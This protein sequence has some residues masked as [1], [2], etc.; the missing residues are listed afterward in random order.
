ME[1]AL[2]PNSSIEELD[3]LSCVEQEKEKE[4]EKKE[5]EKEKESDVDEL[6]SS[7]DLSQDAVQNRDKAEKVRKS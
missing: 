6:K 5:K 3:K 7:S 2:R 4:K 1:I